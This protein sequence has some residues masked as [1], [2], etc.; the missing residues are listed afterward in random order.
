VAEKPPH[1][2]RGTERTDMALT[3]EQRRAVKNVI[4]ECSTSKQI[5]LVVV[6]L[7]NLLSSADNN[8]LFYAMQKQHTLSG[9]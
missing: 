4:D 7:D 5:E 6:L 3:A 1:Q 8:L 9:L 2:I